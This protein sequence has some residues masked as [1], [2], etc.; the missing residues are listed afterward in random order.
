MKSIWMAALLLVVPP[1]LGA[2]GVP[3]GAATAPAIEAER[4]G[5]DWVVEQEDHVTGVSNA[6]QIT[7]PAKVSYDSLMDD[8][9]EMQE[10]KK[11]GI[12]KDS[13]RGQVLVSAAKDRVRRAAKTVMDEKGYC[14][15]WKAIKNKTGTAV[16][17]ITD[18]VRKHLDDE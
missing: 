9:S 7:N 6:Q 5:S 12:K 1:V 2:E 14:S 18:E 16:P 4:S 3:A 17:D 10:L 11:K 13:A 15:V 8:T